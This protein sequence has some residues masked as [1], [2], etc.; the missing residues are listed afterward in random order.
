MGR[1]KSNYY[2]AELISR[3]ESEPYRQ[4]GLKTSNL[5]M[6][7]SNE[8]FLSLKH[9][10][11]SLYISIYMYKYMYVVCVCV[12]VYFMNI[13][14][15]LCQQQQQVLRPLHHSS[16]FINSR[17]SSACCVCGRVCAYIY[18]CVCG[19]VSTSVCVCVCRLYVEFAMD[20]VCFWLACCASY[21]LRK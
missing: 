7:K 16:I 17:T 3:F 20:C 19:C 11:V 4:W 9:I 14:R 12:C 5:P 8:Q 13:C 1:R 21:S 18:E 15:C 6:C 2:I 10:Y